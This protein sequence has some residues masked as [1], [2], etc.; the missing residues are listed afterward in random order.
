M[1]AFHITQWYLINERRLLVRTHV[2]DGRVGRQT[3]QSI[4]V[5]LMRIKIEYLLSEVSSS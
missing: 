1:T 4:V 5:F 3:L 2:A